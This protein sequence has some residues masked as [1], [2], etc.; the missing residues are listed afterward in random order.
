MEYKKVF[1]NLIEVSFKIHSFKLFFLFI[2]LKFI[3]LNMKIDIAKCKK[4]DIIVDVAI[5]W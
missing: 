1:R 2:L 4:A 3:L 5:P